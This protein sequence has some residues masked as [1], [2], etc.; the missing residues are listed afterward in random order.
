MTFTMDDSV[1]RSRCFRIVLN[2]ITLLNLERI[3]SERERERERERGRA[4]ESG[5]EREREREREIEGE[6]DR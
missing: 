1:Q 2:C 6:I 4:R 5:T 3:Q